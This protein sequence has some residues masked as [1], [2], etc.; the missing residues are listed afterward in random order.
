MAG[1]PL[2][3]NSALS[4]ASVCV[5]LFKKLFKKEELWVKKKRKKKEIFPKFCLS[6]V[7]TCREKIHHQLRVHVVTVGPLPPSRGARSY[8]GFPPGKV[9]SYQ[10]AGNLLHKSLFTLLVSLDTCSTRSQVGS[11]AGKIK[12]LAKDCT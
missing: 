8:L 4:R 11:P 1:L 10:K 5:G 3:A 9:E 7:K 12:C 2:I 6:T